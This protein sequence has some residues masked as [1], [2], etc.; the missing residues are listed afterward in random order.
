MKKVFLYV[1]LCLSF[2]VYG[3]PKWLEDLRIDFLSSGEQDF[4]DFFSSPT[5]SLLDNS[6]LYTRSL[7]LEKAYRVGREKEEKHFDAQ[8]QL[9][10]IMF[11]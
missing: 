5:G 4:A 8:Y 10:L 2:K 9:Y 7:A 6:L 11:A 3:I 1:V